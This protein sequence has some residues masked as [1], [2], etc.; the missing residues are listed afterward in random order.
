MLYYSV[1]EDE[2]W[3]LRSYNVDNMK[4]SQIYTNERP[5]S[6]IA[7][8]NNY[9]FY[10]VVQSKKDEIYSSITYRYDTKT[11]EIVETHSP[12]K[13]EIIDKIEN[14]QILWRTQSDSYV[15]DLNGGNR[16]KINFKDGYQY[17]NYKYRSDYKQIG[18]TWTIKLDLYRKNIKTEE[19]KLIA[20]DIGL[21]VFY[22]DKII[23]L[24][25][26]PEKI[27]IGE[28][29]WVTRY[30]YYGGN[31]YIMNLDGSDNRLLCHADN[32]CLSV[33]PMYFCGDWVGLDST[34]YYE[35]QYGDDLLLV[36]IV[37]G[38]YKIVPYNPN[39]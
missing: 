39:E 35:D 23:Y 38:E 4:I 30:D 32:C 9:L 2:Q 1:R 33:P 37:T 29:D 10:T 15:T 31:V 14:G 12:A 5:I 27:L 16:K 13:Y 25:P 18:S 6:N 11:K 21:H 26:L 24:K 17:G 34:N 7:S 8:Y 28:I 19:E 3:F 22:G 36:N 20:E